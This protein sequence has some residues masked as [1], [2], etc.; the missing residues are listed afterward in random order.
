MLTLKLD[1]VLNNES[2][3][4]IVDLLWEFG[5]DGVVSSR[6]LDNETLIAL[7]S[8]EDSWLLDSPFSNICPLLIFVRTLGV[9]LGMGWLPSRLP[10]ICELLDEVG[11]DGGVLQ[12]DMSVSN[13]IHCG[14]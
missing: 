10:V 1:L 12:R 3:A 5:R 8:L 13:R 11:L 14:C 4:L 2:L 6:V 9:L 7:H